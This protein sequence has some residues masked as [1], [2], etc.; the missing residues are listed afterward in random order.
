MSFEQFWIGERLDLDEL[1]NDFA[2]GSGYVAKFRT[3]QVHMLRLT[4][5]KH[6]KHLRSRG[7][8]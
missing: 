7:Y 2:E 6:P 3:A 1:W 5:E 8:L 4:F